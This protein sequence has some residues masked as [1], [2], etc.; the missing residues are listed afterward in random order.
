MAAICRS[1]ASLSVSHM[2]ITYKR[3]SPPLQS[4]AGSAGI[5]AEPWLCACRAYRGS[6]RNM[7]TKAGLYDSSWAEFGSICRSTIWTCMSDTALKP[8]FHG[9]SSDDLLIASTE[10]THEQPIDFVCSALPWTRC[11]THRLYSLSKASK[12]KIKLQFHR[13]YQCVWDRFCFWTP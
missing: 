9:W 4:E 10:R 13:F 8:M 2:L 12:N 11:Q 1:S 6:A 3:L 7:L 5:I